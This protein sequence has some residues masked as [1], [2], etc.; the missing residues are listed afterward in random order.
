MDQTVATASSPALPARS[1]L[2]S[3]DR[4]LSVL[5]AGLADVPSVLAVRGEAGVGKSRLLQE[6]LEG[7]RARPLIGQCHPLRDPFPLGA[8]IEAMRA[9]RNTKLVGLSPL[10]GA[11]HG[12]LPELSA[13]LAPPLE[14]LGDSSAERHR[15][16]RALVEVLRSLGPTVLALEDLHWA[17]PMTRDFLT[18]L[19]SD[20]PAHLSVVVTYREEEFAVAAP[21]W[22]SRASDGVTGI[23]VHLQ[24]LDR[25]GVRD[26]I[27]AILGPVAV[28]DEFTDFMT[29]CT[30]GLPF[31]VEEMLRLLH[32]RRDLVSQDG[33]WFRRELAE[34]PVPKALNDS[35]LERV[36]RLGR[37]AR[38]VVEAVAV[39]G[40]AA[41][42]SLVA[43]VSQLSAESMMV[44]A[45]SGLGAVLRETDDGC[46]SFPHPLARQAVYDSIPAQARRALHRRAAEWIEAQHP[47]RV[48]RLALHTGAAGLWSKW[49]QYAELAA[50]EAITLGNHPTAFMFLD[51]LIASPS[52]AIEERTRIAWTFSDVALQALEH[53]RA[54][55]TLERLVRDPGATEEARGE[56]RLCLARALHQCGDTD[57]AAREYELA[58]H[59]L[60]DQPKLAAM[61]FAALGTPWIGD[62][63]RQEHE[64]W[65]DR[66]TEMARRSG[67]PRIRASVEADRV[68]TMMSFGDPQVFAAAQDLQREGDT[69]DETREQARGLVNV[70]YEAMLLG[71]DAD[72]LDFL[73]AA[74]RKAESAGVVRV[75][76]LIATCAAFLDWEG[77][78][79]NGLQD[80]MHALV[81][82]VDRPRIQAD[83]QLLL[84]LL[85]LARG[86][87]VEAASAIAEAEASAFADREIALAA[88][89]AAALA[90]I[91]IARGGHAEA[92]ARLRPA[93]EQVTRRGIW[94]WAHEVVPLAVQVLTMLSRRQEATEL[95]D[96]LDRGS[97]DCCAPVLSAARDLSQG[98]LL[99][100]ESPTDAHETFS[101]AA[102]A[103]DS[104]GRP[105][106]AAIA[107]EAAGSVTS[108]ASEASL[109][110]ALQQFDEIG[111]IWDAD[112]VRSTLRA[113]GARPPRRPGRS[114]YGDELSPRE[115]EVATLA[116]TGHS[117]SVIAETLFIS[118]KT[119]EKHVSAA[120]RKMEVESREDFA[121]AL[122]Q[123]PGAASEQE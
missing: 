32:D 95:H 12:L 27:Q 30:S 97:T 59:A 46:L 121:A 85:Q 4:E 96:A 107:R 88:M 20:M 93:L 19:V 62:F 10:S 25:S 92:L 99:A 77:G 102:A 120:L 103:W 31:A 81:R 111:A 40:E 105:Y 114:A 24:P 71:H 7:V 13:M 33:R 22:L 56:L 16:F 14:A 69:V 2:V 112:R 89:A 83:A 63:T 91:E 113:R 106:R 37:K 74:R 23:D 39:I 42:Q 64:Q 90:R 72:A 58:A 60:E 86:D 52:L 117:N 76:G 82:D 87:V 67:D 5:L 53:R 104:L 79:W 108:E 109:L 116:A 50:R 28:S 11:L 100:L 66:A 75:E 51:E 26:L 41:D 55:T 68:A 35:V 47:D 73:N 43:A 1:P 29:R 34:I 17:D 9:L 38:T 6:A 98:W 115:R 48:A 80:Q 21:G 123:E 94:A 57:A 44:A 118:V 15:L 49:A 8:V 18:V 122:N 70:A 84:G 36:R 119:V 45:A 78:R 54:A 101:R 110:A 61:A 3:R 65:L